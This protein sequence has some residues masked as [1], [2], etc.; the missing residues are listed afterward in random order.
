[1]ERLLC[2]QGWLREIIP[3]LLQL[4]RSRRRT[5]LVNKDNAIGSANSISV[6]ASS[7]LRGLARVSEPLS[8]GKFIDKFDSSCSR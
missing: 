6:F 4:I 8:A 7:D 3:Y 5:V 2:H 1:M